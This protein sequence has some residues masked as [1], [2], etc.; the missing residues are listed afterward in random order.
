MKIY[1]YSFLWLTILHD[2]LTIITTSLLS[3]YT[4]SYELNLCNDNGKKCINSYSY[5]WY[6]I[7]MYSNKPVIL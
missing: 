5:H 3:S 6:Y 1:Y 4:H 2:Y 7:I